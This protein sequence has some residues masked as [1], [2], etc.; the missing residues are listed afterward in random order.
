LIFTQPVFLIFFAISFMIHWSLPRQSLRKAWLLGASYFFYGYWDWRFLSLILASTLVDYIA[1]RQLVITQQ[2]SRRRW[3]VG[4]SLLLNLGLLG[5]FKY[6]NFFVE[7]GVELLGS[8]GLSASAPTLQLILPV[9]IS[10]FT[11]QSMSYTI[12]IYRGRLTPCRAFLDFALY[13]SFFP[14]LVAGPIVRARTF[15]PQLELTQRL[16]DVEGRALL[17]LFLGGFFKKACIADNI[18]GLIDPVFA[19]PAVFGGADL[20]IAG[21]LYSVQIYCDFSGY[22]DM[23]IAVAGMLGYRLIANFDFPYLSPDIRDFWRRW[24]ISLS[25][26]LRDYLYISLGGNRVG[27]WRAYLNL[28]LTMILG[29]LWHGAN[30]TFVLWGLLHGLALV[31]QRLIEQ[32]RGGPRPVDLAVEGPSGA[33]RLAS[34]LLRGA[35]VAATYLWVAACFTLFRCPD[36]ASA[37]TYFGTLLR[38]PAQIEL[39]PDLWIL[40]AGLAAWHVWNYQVGARVREQLGRLADPLFYASYGAACA[41]VLWFVPANAAP[42]IYFQF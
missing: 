20:A 31:A 39:S 18:A 25:T 40:F 22:T 23:A 19:D 41:A 33:R 29:G 12:D 6:Y 37:A 7:S 2:D 1:G 8:L 10:F 42:F 36:I 30:L 4:A 21:L 13:V 38:W 28:L 15:L 17:L 35:S 26:W 24:H 11:F 5:F 34:A 3:I 16:R 9:G 14:Q 27:R 32:A